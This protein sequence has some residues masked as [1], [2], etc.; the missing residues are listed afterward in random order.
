M[1]KWKD[2]TSFGRSDTDR[3]PRIWELTNNEIR[4][5]LHRHRDYP[6]D[7]RMSCY[8]LGMENYGLHAEDLGAAK[9]E[10]VRKVIA[11]CL[12][13]VESLKEEI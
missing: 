5:L 13:I 4:I 1:S 12:K 8:D 6:G 3:T 7:W 9:K 11:Q 2:V 10:A